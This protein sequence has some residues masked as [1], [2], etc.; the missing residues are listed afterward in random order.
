ME[1]VACCIE[2]RLELYC[3]CYIITNHS[4][5]NKGDITDGDCKKENLNLKIENFPETEEFLIGC[6]NKTTA[7][8]YYLGTLNSNNILYIYGKIENAV[9]SSECVGTYLFNF[10]YKSGRY[11]KGTDSPYY[12]DNIVVQI[13]TIIGKILMANL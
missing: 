4:F 6:K 3:F 7:N 10:F 11:S 9:P 13:A 2:R 5:T 12:Q 8:R 1:N